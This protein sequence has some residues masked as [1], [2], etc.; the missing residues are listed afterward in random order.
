MSRGRASGKHC[1][2]IVGQLQT[3]QRILSFRKDGNVLLTFILEPNGYLGEMK[4]KNNQKPQPKYHPHIMALLL[5]DRVKGIKGAGYAPWMN[6]SV[7]DLNDSNI[8]T[9]VSQKPG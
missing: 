6:F 7:F 3:D 4:A 2:N 1:G 8:K 9:I 5:S